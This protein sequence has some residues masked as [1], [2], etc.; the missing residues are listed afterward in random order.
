MS[1]LPFLVL[2]FMF[3]A[4]KSDV[5]PEDVSKI[6]GYWEIE[7][8]VLPDGNTKDYKIN[9]TIDYFMI[10]GRKGFRKK[11]MPQV[12]GKYLDAG[13]SEKVAVSFN[14]GEAFLNYDS[15][16]AKW[17]EKIISVSDQELVFKNDN[18]LE[19]HY[20]KPVPFSVK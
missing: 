5:Q 15:G 12:D 16:Y 13:T 4:C 2:I 11:V 9:T 6:N 18:N 7:K 20:R 17:K 3:A 8:V 19:Y 14:D 10:D 1:R